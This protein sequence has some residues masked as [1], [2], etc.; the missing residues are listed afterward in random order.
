[1]YNKD[2]NKGKICTIKDMNK[3]KICTIKDMNRINKRRNHC[4]F[5]DEPFAVTLH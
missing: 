4:Q 2:M 3:G 1:M 5:E